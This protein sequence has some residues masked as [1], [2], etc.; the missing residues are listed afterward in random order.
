MFVVENAPANPGTWVLSLIQEDSTYQGPIKPVSHNYYREPQLLRPVLKN[1]RSST[2][3]YAP[4][5]GSLQL[6]KAW[7]KQQR[8][9]KTAIPNNT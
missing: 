6:E 3:E 9:M 7:A 2:K 5:S 1:P 8:E 4:K